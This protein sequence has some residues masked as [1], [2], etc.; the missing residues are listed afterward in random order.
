M[1]MHKKLLASI[2]PEL[3]KHVNNDMREGIEGKIHLPEEKEDVLTL[4]IEWAYTGG[5]SHKNPTLKSPLKPEDPWHSLFKHI[6]LCV[7]ADKFNIPILN[8]LAESKFYTEIDPIKPSSWSDAF[9]L[10][11]MI[12]YAYNNLPSAH[13]ILKFLAQYASWKLVL[14]RETAEFNRLLLN[15]PTFMQEFLKH[16]DGLKAKPKGP[17][18]KPRTR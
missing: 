10:T 1:E 15:Q 9:T 14:L 7:F 4:F 17:Y 6:G 16:L 3:N 8:E 12:G 18:K 13:P 11:I 2:S 5:Y